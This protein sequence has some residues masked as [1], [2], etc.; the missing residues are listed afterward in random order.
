MPLRPLA[1]SAFAAFL[2]LAA[3]ASASAT[4][5]EDAADRRLDALIESRLR[6]GG[7]FFTAPERA[8]IERKCGYAPGSWDGYEASMIGDAFHCTNGRRLRDPETRAI[9][10]AARPRIEA[11]VERVMASPEVRAAIEAVATA[12]AAEAMR[13]LDRETTRRR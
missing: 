12:A 11:R 8:A 13:D 6:A 7:P 5:A 2:A 1:A 9:L 10:A 3:A 4:P